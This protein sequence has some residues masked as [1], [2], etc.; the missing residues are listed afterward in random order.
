MNSG[1]TGKSEENRSGHVPSENSWY[2]SLTGLNFLFET[3]G[4]SP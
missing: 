4:W 1:K 2:F 3:K